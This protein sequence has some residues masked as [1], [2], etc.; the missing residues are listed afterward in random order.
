MT[1]EHQLT[2]A[3]M[4]QPIET[5]PEIHLNSFLVYVPP[6]KTEIFF[7]MHHARRYN[8]KMGNEIRIPSLYG[9]SQER[10][11]LGSMTH[12]M[13]LPPPPEDK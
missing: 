8:D 11:I 10:T 2:E 9:T 5:A 6:S 4:W 7:C 12:W 3:V 13:P 1:N